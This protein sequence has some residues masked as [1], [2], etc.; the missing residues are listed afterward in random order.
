MCHYFHLGS[1]NGAEP[2]WEKNPW[3]KAGIF[4]LCYVHIFWSVFNFCC[5][6]IYTKGLIHTD[7]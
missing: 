1:Q 2:R 6:L 3:N 4:M 7:S 5:C